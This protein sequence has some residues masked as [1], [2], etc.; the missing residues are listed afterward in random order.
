[1]LMCKSTLFVTAITSL[2]PARR[3]H[4]RRRKSVLYQRLPVLSNFEFA[5]CALLFLRLAARLFTQRLDRHPDL[6]HCYD[7]VR[8]ESSSY[9]MPIRSSNLCDSVFL[10]VL[11]FHKTHNNAFPA[12]C[13]KPL[14]QAQERSLSLLTPPVKSDNTLFRLIPRGQSY[15]R[16]GP[17]NPTKQARQKPLASRLRNCIYRQCTGN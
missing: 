12:V 4:L 16:P 8:N 7:A 14:R 11:V 6:R 15:L 13:R 1:L 17:N 3:L 10:N 9:Y 2:P 5:V